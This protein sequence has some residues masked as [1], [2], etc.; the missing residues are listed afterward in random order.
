MRVGH[1][2]DRVQAFQR[3]E[4][5][6]PITINL[7]PTSK[8]NLRCGWCNSWRVLG[9]D[10]LGVDDLKCLDD[11]LT[12]WGVQSMCVAGGG[13]PSLSPYLDIVYDMCRRH[14]LAGS[15]TTNGLQ[16]IPKVVLEGSW[17]V[18]VSVDAGTPAT[19]LALKGIDKF[20]VCVDNIRR[21]VEIKRLHGY[22]CEISF[23]YLVHPGNEHDILKAYALA[24]DLGCDAFHV[25][26]AAVEATNFGKSPT[27][28][29]SQLDELV[30]G[31]HPPTKVRLV[32]FRFDMSPNDFPR[33]MAWM[34]ASVL[35]NGKVG[36]CSNQKGWPPTT[37][38]DLKDLRREWCGPRHRQ[39][40]DAIDPSKCPKC[41]NIVDFH[42]MSTY[43]DTKV[44]M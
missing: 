3:G 17:W 19:Y 13:E 36:F 23:K 27:L 31:E 44:W 40:L 28:D 15:F 1:Y 32:D 38:C 35:A 39:L 37:L 7:D 2:L 24:C 43:K 18:G 22:T 20:D 30:K 29:L 21:A 5:V 14:N 4:V 16:V 25:R 11:Q 12:G 6:A 33:C 8:C 10:T 26:P 41:P 34:G 42:E 9:H